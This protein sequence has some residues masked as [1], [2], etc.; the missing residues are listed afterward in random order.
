VSAL[1][2]YVDVGALRVLVVGGGAV[3]TRKVKQL[4]EAQSNI[5]VVAPVLSEELEQLVRS[6]AIP[7]ERRAYE[8]DDI[9]DAQLVF[10]AT[11]DRAVNEQVARDANAQHRLV[12]V[13]DDA[14]GGVFSLM[15]MHRRGPLTIAV[16]AGG[17]PA[18]A[19]RIR[20][21]IAE[22][23]DAR[24]GDALGDLV[25]LRRQ[26]L[27]AGKAEQWHACAAEVI[28]AD[29]CER[30]EKGDIGQSAAPWR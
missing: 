29:F 25:A 30:V 19:L 2:L 26:L 11:N 15:A 9:G 27:S 7:V 16:N 13:T 21:A 20:D 8:S 17:V 5:R 28:D 14:H 4:A 3:A 6:F 18:A 12:N 24:Y 22:R 23:F 10:A 1:P